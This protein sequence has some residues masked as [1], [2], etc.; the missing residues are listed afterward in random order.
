MFIVFTYFFNFPSGIY[1]YNAIFL[2]YIEI[3]ALYNKL[4]N[5]NISVES[6][7]SG[8]VLIKCIFPLRDEKSLRHENLFQC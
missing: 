1:F 3:Y 4:P 8:S 7:L 6:A 2:A 5:V